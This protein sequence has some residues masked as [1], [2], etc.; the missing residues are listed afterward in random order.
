MTTSKGA[1]PKIAIIAPSWGGP[2]V[3]PHIYRLGVEFLNEFFETT[4]VELESTRKD[5]RFLREHPEYRANELEEA[6]TVEEFDYIISAI[7]GEESIRILKYLNK[8]KLRQVKHKPIFM[9][10]SDVTSIHIFLNQLGYLTYYGPSVMA[11][12]AQAKQL[13]KEFLEHLTK[14]FKEK[15]DTIAYSPYSFYVEGY[16]DWADVSKAGQIN[17]RIKNTAKWVFL[18]PSNNTKTKVEGVIL[19]GSWEIF[20]QFRGTK[21]ID[22]GYLKDKILLLEPSEEVSKTWLRVSLIALGEI[23][24]YNDIKA[25]IIGRARGG[26]QTLSLIEDAVKQIVYN[27]YKADIPIV[28]NFDSGHTDPQLIV[29][30]GGDKVVIDLDR[31]SIVW[32]REII[33]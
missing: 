16:P 28:L 24:V 19:G 13:G 14:V 6:L 26:E 30:L 20:D 8:E 18:T 17:P 3:F 22:Y 10:F 11:G 4:V 29:P 32:Q 25:L 5:A 9:G 7:G 23:G 33:R 12:F 15:L 1:S 2:S 31:K 27:D 21:H